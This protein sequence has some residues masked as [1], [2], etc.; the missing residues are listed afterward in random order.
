MTDHRQISV[1]GSVLR[2]MAACGCVK[3]ITFPEQ[4]FYFEVQFP[5]AK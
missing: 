5:A 1:V 3:D 2:E 4:G